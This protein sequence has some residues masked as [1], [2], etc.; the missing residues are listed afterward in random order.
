M[1]HAAG[2]TCVDEYLRATNLVVSRLNMPPLPDPLYDDAKAK[3]EKLER[4]INDAFLFQVPRLRNHVGTIALQQQYAGELRED[5]ESCRRELQVDSV[6]I[7]TVANIH[8]SL[9]KQILEAFVDDVVTQSH[10][11]ELYD[12]L[13]ILIP[14]VEE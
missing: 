3:L 4:R 11:K 7:Y 2:Q 9:G 13:D 6:L 1:P 10:R 12:Q 5:I 8:G 14:R